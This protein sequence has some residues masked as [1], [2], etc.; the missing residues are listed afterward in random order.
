MP[1]API[2]IQKLVFSIK[3]LDLV[4]LRNITKYSYLNVRKNFV[5]TC[6]TKERVETDNGVTCDILFSHTIRTNNEGKIQFNITHLWLFK[7]NYKR[8]RNN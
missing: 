6:R 5:I 1:F 3:Q 2:I 8:R 7:Y 4:Q